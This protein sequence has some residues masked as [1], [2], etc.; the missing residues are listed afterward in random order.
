M[1]QRFNINQV[2]EATNLEECEIRF[3]EQ[4]FREFLAFSQLSLDKNE[5]TQD[6]VDV[7]CRIRRLIHEEARS[8][9]EVKRELKAALRVSQE[10]APAQIPLPASHPENGHRYARV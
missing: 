4:V 5:F 10:G 2:A 1:I 3:F 6:H 9:D 7:L 8:I